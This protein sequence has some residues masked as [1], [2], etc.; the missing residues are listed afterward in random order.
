MDNT[1]DIILIMILPDKKSAVRLG[2]RSAT[3]IKKIK[4]PPEGIVPLER[5]KAVLEDNEYKLISK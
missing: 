5:W 1:E 4:N 2:E 3:S